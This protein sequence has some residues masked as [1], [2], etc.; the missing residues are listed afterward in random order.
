MISPFMPDS[1]TQTYIS[2]SFFFFFAAPEISLIVFSCLNIYYSIQ[3][4][5]PL[6]PEGTGVTL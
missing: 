1:E 2:A 4:V 5:W 6:A 3:I